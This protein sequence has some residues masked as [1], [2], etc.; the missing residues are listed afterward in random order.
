MTGKNER[1][2]PVETEF[3]ALL[4]TRSNRSTGAG[5]KVSTA[6]R[7]VLA[8]AVDNIWIFWINSTDK[9][10][11]ASNGNPIFVHDTASKSDGWSA[12]RSV[13]LQAAVD[14]VRFGWANRGMIELSQGSRVDVVPVATTIETHVIPA[15]R[16]DDHVPAIAGIDPQVVRVRVD[17]TAQIRGEGLTTVFGSILRNA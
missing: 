1:S 13:V 11:T 17:A 16:S 5:S 3:L 14:A 2:I 8:L 12:P 15:V 4:R 7:S 10:I 9:T 6:N